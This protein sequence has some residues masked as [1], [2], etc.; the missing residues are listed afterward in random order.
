MRDTLPI[1]VHKNECGVM[2]LDNVHGPGTHWVCYRKCD[3]IVYYYDSFGNLPPPPELILYFNSV[4]SNVTVRY[5]YERQ[6]TFDTVIC[7]HLC[8]RFLCTPIS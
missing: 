8:L 7:G 1:T 2:N 5:N 3:N 6:Q 4:G